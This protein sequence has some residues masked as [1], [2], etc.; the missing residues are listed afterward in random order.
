M[1]LAGCVAL[2]PS[3]QHVPAPVGTPAR[4][5]SF[6]GSGILVDGDQTYDVE[7]RYVDADL[8]A[9]REAAST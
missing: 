1:Q 5:D 9:V 7:L 3:G 2:L 6:T 4:V 8:R